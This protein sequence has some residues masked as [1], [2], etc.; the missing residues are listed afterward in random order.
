MPIRLRRLLGPLLSVIFLLAALVSMRDVIRE[1]SL[2]QVRDAILNT[3]TSRLLLALLC[4]AAVYGILSV[5]DVLAFRYFRIRLPLRRI[6]FASFAGN[7]FGMTLGFALLTGGSLRYRLYSE[8]GFNLSHVAKV[9]A[10]SVATFI[11]LLLLTSGI[12]LTLNAHDLSL[13]L[14]LPSATLRLIGILLLTPVFLYLLSSVVLPHR[15]FIFRS[16]ELRVP[17]FPIALGQLLLTGVE[18]ALT[19]SLLYLLLPESSIP[20]QLFL[21]L[22]VLSQLMSFVSQVPSGLGVFDATMM[23]LLRQY[24]GTSVILGALVMFRLLFYALPL[25]L[26]LLSLF[27]YEV[28]QYVR[29]TGNGNTVPAVPP[30]EG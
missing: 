18:V 20:L 26:A 23:L 7:T 8:W 4:T 19:G 17:N 27:S 28:R 22:Y 6:M 25:L 16:W 10:F 24:Y 1:V 30:Q 12:G 21:S 14:P 9:T 5:Y 2:G 11:L 29:E 13:F 15:T 3:P